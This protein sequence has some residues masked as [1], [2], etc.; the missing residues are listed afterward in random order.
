MDKSL[1]QIIYRIVRDGK[2]IVKVFE[3]TDVKG[4]VMVTDSLL[5]IALDKASEILTVDLKD[6][7]KKIQK[8]PFPMSIYYQFEVF[9]FS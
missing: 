6:G 3:H 1:T 4:V 9:Y 7:T 5:L 2:N 8:A